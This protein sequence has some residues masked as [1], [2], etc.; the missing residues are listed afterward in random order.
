M[1]S[2]LVILL[3]C[4]WFVGNA[5][6]AAGVVLG[7]RRRAM[8]RPPARDPGDLAPWADATRELLRDR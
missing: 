7:S 5:L 1:V 6:T 8:R 3:L 2:E 4:A